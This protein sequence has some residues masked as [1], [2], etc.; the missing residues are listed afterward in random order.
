MKVT[1]AKNTSR[2]TQFASGFT[3]AETLVAMALGSIMSVVVGGLSIYS[4][5]NF[6]A[7]SNYMDLDLHSRNAL[8]VISEELRQATAVT[9]YSTNSSTN[10]VTLTNATTATQL[11]LYWNPTAATL[12]FQK[13]G[14]PDLTCLTGCDRWNFALYTR[15]PYITPTNLYFNVAT[16]LN[17]CKLLSMSWKCSRT[18]LG[19]KL[20]TENVQT[21]QI[22]L[23]NKVN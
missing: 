22:V 23:R 11:K 14:Q 2:L 18:I 4:A 10:Y 21:A 9:G 13:T 5:H 6:T 17:E 7:M 8:D 19:S 12:V 20:N 3:L 1:S 16:N 15:A